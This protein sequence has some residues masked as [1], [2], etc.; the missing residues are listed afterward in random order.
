MFSQYRHNIIKRK[1]VW[2]L[3]DKTFFSPD[4]FFLWYFVN[5]IQYSGSPTFQ[6]CTEPSSSSGK[7]SLSQTNLYLLYATEELFK[8]K[9]WTKVIWPDKRTDGPTDN[10]FRGV[11][12]HLLIT[13]MRSCLFHFWPKSCIFLGFKA[14]LE[15]LYELWL[16]AKLDSIPLIFKLEFDVTMC[17]WSLV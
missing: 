17:A 12:F 11:R 16:K 9:V 13:C 10:V 7:Y 5:V 6:S 8:P 1:K 15:K 4:L 2:K 3:P 14:I